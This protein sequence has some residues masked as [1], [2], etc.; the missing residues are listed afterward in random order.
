MRAVRTRQP[1]LTRPTDAGSSFR[2]GFAKMDSS[3]ALKVL[4]HGV[5]PRSPDSLCGYT[6]WKTKNTARLTRPAAS[7]IRRIV[8]SIGFSM[9]GGAWRWGEIQNEKTHQHSAIHS[10]IKLHAM[11]CTFP[12]W[13]GSDGQKRMRYGGDSEDCGSVG[14]VK[15]KVDP[16]PGVLSTWRSRLWA[17]RMCFTMARPSPLPPR[18]R[19]RLSSTR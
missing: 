4:R 5:A 13:A 7:A 18:L 14:K 6:K 9:V 16:S 1:L 2:R 3:S 15:L 12:W 17:P 11:R 19:D 8:R 10:K